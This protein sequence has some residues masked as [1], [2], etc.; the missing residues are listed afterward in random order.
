MP[1][2]GVMNGSQGMS[3]NLE[4]LI[5]AGVVLKTPLPDDVMEVIAGMSTEDVDVIVDLKARFDQ[6]GIAAGREEGLTF[7]SFIII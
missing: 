4:R 2:G 3:E 5:E 1:K 7:F 6:S